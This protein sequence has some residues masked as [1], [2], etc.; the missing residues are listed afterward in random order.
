MPFLEGFQHQ[1]LAFGALLAAV[2]FVIHLLNRQRHRP[3][4]WAA[5]RFVMAAYKRTRRRSQ[6]ENLLLL[7]LRMAAVALLAFALARPF[8]STE[9]PLAQLTETRRDVVCVL[10]TSAST[11]YRESVDSVFE[12]ILERARELFGDLDAERG[13]RVRLIAAAGSPRLLSWR[14]PEDA[15]SVLSTLVVPRAEELDLDAALAEVVRLAEEDETGVVAG[16]LEVRLLTDMQRETFANSVWSS[17]EEGTPSTEGAAAT[18]PLDRLHELG[19]KVIVEDLGPIA[20]VPPNLGVDSIRSIGQILGPGIP[21]EI[22]VTVRN[23]GAN[24]A[25]G[26]RLVLFVDGE[27][28]PVR[29]IEVPARSRF[30]AVFPIVFGSSGHHV[31]EARLQG[32]G[33][34]I[35]DSH[36][37]VVSVPPSLRVLLVNGDPHPDIDRDEVGFLRAVLE[38]LDDGGFQQGFAPFEPTVIPPVVL[39]AG[40]FELA[41]QD[42]VVLA[43]VESVSTRTVEQLEKFVSEGGALI[44]TVGDRV[45]PENYNARLFRSD[46]TGLLPA[47]ILR[48]VEVQ[49]RREGYFRASTFDDEHPALAFFADDRWRPLFSEAPI[50]AFLATTPLEDTRVLASLDDE[51]A[52]PLL[53]ERAYDRGRVFLWTTSIDPGWT[54]LPESPK[55]LVPFVHELV[56]HAGRPRPGLRNTPVGHA[57][58]LEVDTFPRMMTL[59]RPDGK[60]RSLE[61]E[62]VDAGGVWLLPPLPP[63][64]EVGLW[65]VE[66]EGTKLAFSVQFDDDEGDLSRISGDEVAAL[67]PAFLPIVPGTGARSD[68]AGEDAHTGELWRGFARFCLFALILESLWAGLI[69]RRRRWNP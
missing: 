40:D 41:E 29:S 42:V 2:P 36:F 25:S 62:P 32:D 4:P 59:V 15:L 17:E 28:Q 9:S 21:T 5:M 1:A 6:L 69:G 60:S 64:D 45:V 11:G 34:A 27:R 19:V 7:L 58:A 20:P 54:R 37:R 13:D 38:P 50:Y 55:S 35:D 12:R 68:D 61:G 67:H 47:E 14:S 43:N 33:L 30:E 53:L 52:S 31:V 44:I 8:T 49:S 57:L 65:Y 23:H 22:G 48:R 51:N 63:L 24:I 26:V 46:G 16:G 66:M 10:D 39:A 56:R 3:M 18:R